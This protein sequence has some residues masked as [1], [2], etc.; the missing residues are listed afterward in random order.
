MIGIIY[1]QDIKNCPFLSKYTKV[2]EENNIDY[3]IIYWNRNVNK[4]NGIYRKGNFVEYSFYQDIRKPKLKKI[5]GF[6][7]YKM[8]LNKELKEC[9]KLVF[10]TTLSAF[11]MFDKIN[12]YKYIFDF[13]DPSFEQN[14]LFKKMID[15]IIKKSY[16]TCISSKA[17]K[18][19]LPKRKYMLAHNFRYE[20]IIQA[21]ENG[22][23]FKKKDY[24]EKLVVTYHGAIREF[25][26]IKKQI[27]L[28]S[29]DERFE[30]Y[31]YGYGSEYE[32]LKLFID[33]NN[34]QNIHLMGEYNNNDK[35]KFLQKTDIINNHYP[36]C[37]NYDL[38][39]SNKFYD[40]L[41]YQI[42]LLSNVGC[43]D[44]L[45]SNKLFGIGL[46]LNTFDD[47]DTLYEWYFGIETNNFIDN[48]EKKLNKILDDDKEYLNSIRK[49]VE[50]GGEKNV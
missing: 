21:K 26:H 41:I 6:L 50:Y 19:I 7:K 8:F 36:L 43:I 23:C 28:L 18:K 38:C 48:C 12:K 4:E 14:S 24:G 34:F 11:L 5:F 39:T 42:P 10:L 33:S 25:E 29:Q 17:F 31:Y 49:F 27:I 13:R 3:K 20:D 47:L 32:S 46:K 45:E 2:F 15:K 16:F 9:D 44:D 22:Y 30:V 37:N 40:S 1:I 35:Y